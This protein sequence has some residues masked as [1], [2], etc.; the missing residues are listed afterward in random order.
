M[1]A[2]RHIDH[3]VNCNAEVTTGPRD[4]P[5][6]VPCGATVWQSEVQDALPTGSIGEFRKLLIRRGWQLGARY[7]DRG[8]AL[9]L[10]PAHRK[11]AAP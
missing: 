1:T 5:R 10:C 2:L 9:D 6:T 3:G 8:R 7:D 4:A 11:D